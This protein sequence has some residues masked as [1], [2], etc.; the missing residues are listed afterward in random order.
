[1]V[2][3]VWETA[4]RDGPL[5]IGVTG[6][7]KAVAT[8]LLERDQTPLAIRDGAVEIALRPHG[9]AAIRLVP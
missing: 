6:F 3:R 4:G 2:L 1:M 8:D 5:R 9:Y 7:G